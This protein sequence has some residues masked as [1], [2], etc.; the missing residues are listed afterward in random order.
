MPVALNFRAMAL[1]ASGNEE[2]D[3]QARKLDTGRF[4]RQYLINKE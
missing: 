2:G 3:E 1:Y 4:S